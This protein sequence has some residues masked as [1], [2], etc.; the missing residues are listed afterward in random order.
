MNLGIGK[1][2]QRMKIKIRVFDS[3]AIVILL[4]LCSSLQAQPFGKIS[5]TITDAETRAPL[6]GANISVA[7]TLLGASTDEN[8]RFVIRRMPPGNYLLKVS[9]IGYHTAQLRVRVQQDSTT[10]MQMTLQP[11]AIQSETIIVTGSRQQED[12]QRAANSV[13]VV[14]ATEIRQRNRFR[15][16][17]S[18]QSIAGVTL[19]GENVNVRGGTGYA[20]LGLGASRVLM[21]IDDVPVLTSDL[22][23]ANWDILPVTEVER[24]E[25]LKGAASVLYGSGGISG[26]VN[27]L[28]RRPTAA[29]SV[30]F[31]VSVGL[32]DD[33]SVPEW[34]WTDRSL[35]YYRTDLSYG[36]TFNRFGLRL[37]VSRHESTGDRDPGDFQRWYFTGKAV[38]TLPDNS[39]LTLFGTYSR[40]ERGF[41]FKL[42]DL[43]APLVS[44]TKD[45]INVD[46]SAASLIYNK[47]FSP[48]FSTKI[49]LSFNSQLIGLPSELAKDFKPALG[50]SGEAQGNWLPHQDHSVVFGVDYKREEAESKYY[51]THR[52]EAVSPYLQDIWK[53][54]NLWQIHAGL[55][56]DTYILVGDSAETQLSP[57]FGASYN[58]LPNSIAHISVGR[59]FRSPSIAE[60]FSE[61]RSR[62]GFELISNPDLQ[63]ERSTLFDVG[64]RQRFGESASAE[65]TAFLN[66][67]DNLIELDTQ[68]IPVLS[69]LNYPRTRMRG[70]ETEFKGRWWANRLGLEAALTWMEA[71]S[72]SDD[73]ASGLKENQRLPYRPKFTA[74]V[75]PSFSLGPMTLEADYRYVS[76]YDKTLTFPEEVPQKTWDVRWHYRWHE[77]A[78]QLGMKNAVNYNYA[79]VERNIGEIRSFYASLYGEF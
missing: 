25:V 65:V 57:K 13:N 21:L 44:D 72:L 79:P 54:S 74:F 70:I 58:F 10:T 6:A 67:Y 18:L 5:G 46:G 30:S 29:P 48:T 24:V 3:L 36:Q 1:P 40:D 52:G 37:A 73:P 34:K 16:D 43:N 60:R 8:G 68:N 41:F 71:I 31:R 33:P 4:S 61:F 42:Q 47:L 45:K 66:H 12:L 11:S 56:Y 14:A 38:Y 51:G 2:E 15:I 23:R 39:N 28:T 9:F 7:Q 76:L 27:I 20:L 26:V 50:L 62:G 59:G 35:Y 69:F 49:R 19:I 77:L 22:G 32:Y 64:V 17:E 53:I 55:R 63:P 75:S 78:L